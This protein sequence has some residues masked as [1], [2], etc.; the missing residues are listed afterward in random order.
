MGLD[1]DF[2][3]KNCS[4]SMNKNWLDWKFSQLDFGLAANF[5][6]GLNIPVKVVVSCP[7]SLKKALPCA[8]LLLIIIS[9]GVFDLEKIFPQ[10]STIPIPKNPSIKCICT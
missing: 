5:K 1:F 8:F 6:L 10:Q 4:L 7:S 9:F 2:I 3:I